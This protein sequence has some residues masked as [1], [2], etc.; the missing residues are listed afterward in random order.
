MADV[1]RDE[2]L[3]LAIRPL[4]LIR[5]LG[6]VEEVV[7]ETPDTRY[8]Y[9]VASDGV[10]QGAHSGF[11][12]QGSDLDY[13]LEQLGLQSLEQLNGAQVYLH[14]DGPGSRLYGISAYR[15]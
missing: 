7:G 4:G 9:V 6:T 14:H 13:L 3:Y 11:P 15:N 10:L 12:V 8:I 1:I 2:G 5:D